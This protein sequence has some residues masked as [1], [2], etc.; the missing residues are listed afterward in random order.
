MKNI[1]L[2]RKPKGLLFLSFALLMVLLS[3]KGYGQVALPH[4]DPLNYTATQSLPA[5]TGWTL[6]NTATSDMLITSGS[7]SYSGFVQ[8]TGNKVAFG[9]TGED[10]AK[11]FTQQ[12]TGTVY[13]SFLLNV[14]S[15]G[16]LNTTGGY[17]TGFTEGTSNTFGAT[18]W[19]RL[20]GSGYNIGINPKTTAANTVWSS[21]VNTV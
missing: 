17:F 21:G 14:S 8:P 9:G 5:Q 18:V 1:L 7:L 19:T 10:V 16:S 4:L 2:F 12:T 11:L 6:I 13:Y 15:L 20:S 3:G